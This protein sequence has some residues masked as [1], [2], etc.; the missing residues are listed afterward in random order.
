M[1]TSVIIRISLFPILDNSDVDKKT[2]FIGTG[3]IIMK[4]GL[5]FC[6]SWFIYVND[7]C[8]RNFTF[9]KFLNGKSF[10]NVY[11]VSIII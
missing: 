6:T 9:S 3:D 11:G 10:R 4:L 7:C 1:L 8:R 5:E 2:F